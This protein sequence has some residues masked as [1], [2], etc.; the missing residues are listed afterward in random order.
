MQIAV[1]ALHIVLPVPGILGLNVSGPKVWTV[2]V[3]ASGGALLQEPAKYVGTG[4]LSD[5]EAI[6]LCV[7]A[8]ASNKHARFA[9]LME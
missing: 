5:K 1:A 3:A 4:L 6:K 2:I 7:Y 8:F 9:D